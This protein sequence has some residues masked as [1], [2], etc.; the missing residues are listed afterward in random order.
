MPN[1]QNWLSAGGWVWARVEKEVNMVKTF[2]AKLSKNYQKKTIKKGTLGLQNSPTYKNKTNKMP[3]LDSFTRFVSK[4]EIQKQT[5][6][7]KQNLPYVGS[8][9]QSQ[10]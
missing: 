8:Y 10:I 1:S 5:K 7:N 4:W 6:Q 9:K 2:S 3:S